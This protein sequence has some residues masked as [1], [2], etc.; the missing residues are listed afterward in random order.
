M[1]L[2]LADGP[3]LLHAEHGVDAGALA[4]GGGVAALGG[5]GGLLGGRGGYGL[6]RGLA[7][8][9]VG[10]G[11]G[12]AGRRDAR[13]GSLRL[14]GGLEIDEVAGFFGAGLDGRKSQIELMLHG[15]GDAMQLPDELFEFLGAAEVQAAVPE[16]ADGER[17]DDGQADGE[18]GEDDGK[19]Q[20]VEGAE[21]WGHGCLQWQERAG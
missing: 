8:Y 20:G 21:G 7:G 4:L 18:R 10:R 16:E 12:G 17:E 13:G 5:R 9:G 19:K 11:C 14:S 1:F 3:V 2:R 6:R 15:A